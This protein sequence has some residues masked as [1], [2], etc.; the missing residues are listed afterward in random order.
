VAHVDHGSGILVYEQA[1]KPSLCQ[2]II[3]K[4]NTDPNQIVEVP[5]VDENRGVANYRKCTTIF[6]SRLPLWAEIN[7]K[8]V[9]AVDGCMRDY[10]KRFNDFLSVPVQDSGFEIVKY[11]AGDVCDFH[12]DGGPQQRQIFAS[13]IIF[14]NTLHYPGHGA[15]VFTE[16]EK[17]IQAVEG[18]L[19]IF[20]STFIHRHGTTPAIENRYVVVTFMR[21]AK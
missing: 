8:L 6:S 21:Y 18:N 1:I 9:L 15:L 3:Q 14:L 2:E 4:F 11:T 13:V 12:T 19:L 10:S 5:E 17:V 7:E 20:P 16:Q